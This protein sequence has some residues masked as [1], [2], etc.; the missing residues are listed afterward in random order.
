MGK[1]NKL[2]KEKARKPV[3][4]QAAQLVLLVKRSFMAIG[5]TALVTI[6]LMS[7]MMINTIARIDQHEISK[8]LNQYRTES[9]K[10]TNDIQ[11]YA[12]TG[13]NSYLTDYNE[14]IAAGKREQAIEML[15]SKNLEEDEWNALN[16]VLEKVAKLEELEQMI[17][18]YVF[19]N[20]LYAF[21]FSIQSLFNFSAG[22]F[23][24]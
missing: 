4:G 15:H 14:K 1:A 22:L 11:A 13:N 18:K 20:I 6:V 17:I 19:Q 2:L 5:T 16:V 7:V 8:A 24:P 12:V 21:D 9:R 10:L 3:L 23:H